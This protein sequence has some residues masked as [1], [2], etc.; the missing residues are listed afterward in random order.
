[1]NRRNELIGTQIFLMAID[2]MTPHFGKT[3]LQNF[4]PV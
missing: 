1:M 4:C 2:Q 3:I